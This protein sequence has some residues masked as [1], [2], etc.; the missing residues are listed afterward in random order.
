MKKL[1][2]TL[3]A[4]ALS[5]SLGVGFCP[6]Y[7]SN[8]VYTCSTS[9]DASSD[10]IQLGTDVAQ[11]IT[12]DILPL[13]QEIKSTTGQIKTQAQKKQTHTKNIAELSKANALKEKQL[14]F[15]YE[16]YKKLL[17]VYIDMEATA[18]LLKDK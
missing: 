18:A 4:L 5:H 17:A 10:I 14:A 7:Y 2:T 6:T 13:Y 12:T 1:T 15:Q 8:Q 16:K 11:D 3:I 9:A